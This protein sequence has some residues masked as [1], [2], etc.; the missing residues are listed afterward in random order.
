MD[1]LSELAEVSSTSVGK[2]ERGAQ[3][4][5]AET[6]VR[7]AAALEIDAGSLI[8]GL[9]PKDYGERTHGYS[10]RDFLRERRERGESA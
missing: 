6:L 7:I 5:T 1:D 10:V 8:S 9:Q 2:I 3:S 4:P